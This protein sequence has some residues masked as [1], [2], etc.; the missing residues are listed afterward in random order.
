M[1]FCPS[2]SIP[3]TVLSGR[4]QRFRCT[5]SEKKCRTRPDSSQA[6]A[7]NLVLRPRRIRGD[8]FARSARS[9]NGF[10]IK[11]ASLYLHFVPNIF[12]TPVYRMPVCFGFFSEGP[13]VGKAAAAGVSSTGKIKTNSTREGLLPPSV[14]LMFVFMVIACQIVQ[15]QMA[16]V[17]HFV[18][19]IILPS[20]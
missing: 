14:P 4:G 1:C 10:V 2:A 15:Q 5:T 3:N 13:S 6:H 16:K 19:V 9:L 18:F 12:F 11:H 17:T 20:L 7:H 8:V